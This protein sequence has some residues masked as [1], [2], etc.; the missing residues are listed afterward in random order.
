MLK[1]EGRR[2]ETWRIAKNEMKRA[3]CRVIL[4]ATA[5][6]HQPHSVPAN[7]PTGWALSEAFSIKL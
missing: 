1:D 3:G 6:L 2:Q 7:I 4:N 5:E